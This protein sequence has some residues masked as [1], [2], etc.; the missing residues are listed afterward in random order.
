MTDK[1]KAYEEKLEAQLNK[2]NA[3]IA[4][5]KAKAEN[6]KADTK[7]EYEMTLETLQHKRDRVGS[8]LQ[9]LKNAGDGAWG[10]LKAGAV[11]AWAEVK[12]A[13]HDSASQFK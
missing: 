5:L 9:H 7:I 2:W 3:E 8:K 13:F 6:A 10:D 4:L 11:K 12:T 1:R